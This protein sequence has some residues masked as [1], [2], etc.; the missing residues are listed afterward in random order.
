MNSSE[1]RFRYLQSCFE[2]VKMY[3]T[4]KK[5]DPNYKKEGIEDALVQVAQAYRYGENVKK[6]YINSILIYYNKKNLIL[7]FCIFINKILFNYG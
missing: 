6:D 4:A 7:Y 1:Q 3:E 2:Q 5:I